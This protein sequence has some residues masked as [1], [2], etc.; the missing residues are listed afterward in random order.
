MEFESILGGSDNIVNQIGSLGLDI[1]KTGLNA[2]AGYNNHF[3]KKRL[4][5]P[6][7]QEFGKMTKIANIILNSDDEDEIT[8]K[9]VEK[10]SRLTKDVKSSK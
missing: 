6:K 5:K 8:E 7:I 10:Q 9:E 4:L 2:V 1:I 3:H